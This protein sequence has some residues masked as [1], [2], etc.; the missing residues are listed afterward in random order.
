M[1]MIQ[2][3]FM[4]K[5]FRCRFFEIKIGCKVGTCLS[6]GLDSSAVVAFA[7][8]KEWKYF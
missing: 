5:L 1:K 8:Q 4:K 6:G 3:I 7:N 2:L